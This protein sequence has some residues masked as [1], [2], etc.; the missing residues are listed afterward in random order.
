M[1]PCNTNDHDRPVYI[2]PLVNEYW[3]IICICHLYFMT[4]FLIRPYKLL[5]RKRFI[6]FPKGQ[7]KILSRVLDILTNGSFGSFPKPKNV[8]LYVMDATVSN[9]KNIDLKSLHTKT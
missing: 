5:H 1:T 4:L 6:W 7:K 2:L 3:P 9:F 8:T